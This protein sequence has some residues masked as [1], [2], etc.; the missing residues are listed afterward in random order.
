MLHETL[1]YMGSDRSGQ[2]S[3][4]YC[5]VLCNVWQGSWCAVYSAGH[6]TEH[7]QAASFA[8]PQLCSIVALNP[9][10][11]WLSM[12][13]PL[14]FAKCAPFGLLPEDDKLLSSCPLAR[15]SCFAP[16]NRQATTLVHE[17]GAA[18][19]GVVLP[20]QLAECLP[21]IGVQC[22]ASS[23]LQCSCSWCTSTAPRTRSSVLAT[24][25]GGAS[26]RAATRGGVTLLEPRG[27][28]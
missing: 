18:V 3:S 9:C 13:V 27:L 1:P 25:R 12:M 16:Y 6:S 4:R 15:V 10:S 28:P 26:T 22:L 20:H 8:L 2:G 24:S 17:H 5:V 19:P 23:G 11:G 14:P 7:D 21:S